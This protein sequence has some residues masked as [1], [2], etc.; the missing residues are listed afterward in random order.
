MDDLRPQEV[1][2]AATDDRTYPERNEPPGD[3]AALGD[4]ETLDERVLD[5]IRDLA[6]GSF[7]QTFG[8]KFTPK[9]VAAG[10]SACDL[11]GE[12][13]HKVGACPAE[14]HGHHESASTVRV[15]NGDAMNFSDRLCKQGARLEE[16]RRFDP[17]QRQGGGGTDCGQGRHW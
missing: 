10:S 2:A 5:P 14:H 6:H 4:R 15:F 8:D 16:A 9:T 11:P 3:V 7:R 1:V 17:R 12:L 13:A